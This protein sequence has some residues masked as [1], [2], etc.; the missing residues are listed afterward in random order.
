MRH[1]VEMMPA[2]D[3]YFRLRFGL[4]ISIILSIKVIS[5]IFIGVGVLKPI[6]CIRHTKSD[7]DTQIKI[8]YINPLNLF[9]LILNNHYEFP[10]HTEICTKYNSNKIF[11][12]IRYH[13][14]S[15]TKM[16]R[17]LVEPTIS[18]LLSL[19]LRDFT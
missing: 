17:C 11:L 13:N 8:I 2:I 1:Y 7:Y 19:I 12:Q 6:K 5:G 16:H 9:F 14:G 4:V 3:V 10:T 15:G 18:F